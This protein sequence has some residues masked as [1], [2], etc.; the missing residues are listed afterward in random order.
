MEEPVPGWT[1]TLAA[2]GGFTIALS[3]G[4]IH[5]VKISSKGVLDLIP[6]DYCSNIIIAAAVFRALDNS[7]GVHVVHSATSEHSEC[8]IEKFRK[9]FMNYVEYHPYVK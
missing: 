8:T 9:G 3:L 7:E 1:D 5:F 2:A 4:V 6:A